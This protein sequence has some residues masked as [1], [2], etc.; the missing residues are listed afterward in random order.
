MAVC[1]IARELR[2]IWVARKISASAAASDPA[3]RA[4]VSSDQAW[5]NWNA[6]DA[7]NATAK[8]TKTPVSS[9][10]TVIPRRA[11]PIMYQPRDALEAHTTG[12]RLRKSYEVRRRISGRI[13]KATALADDWTAN[14]TKQAPVDHQQRAAYYECT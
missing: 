8:T 9:V 1:I 2:C 10:P 13:L 11:L 3:R 7:V 4:L 14:D 5:L 12:N 6:S